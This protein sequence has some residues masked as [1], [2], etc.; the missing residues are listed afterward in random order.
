MT[1]VIERVRAAEQALGPGPAHFGLMH[2]DLHHHNL[3][4]ARGA[5]KARHR[6]GDRL[7]RLWLRPAALRP[8]GAAGGAAG[9]ARRYPALRAALLAGYRRV[10]PLPPAHEAYLDTFIALRRVQDALWVLASR[11]HPAI[12]LDWAAQAR[13]MMA[14]L[15]GFLARGAASPRA[16]DPSITTRV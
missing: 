1:A 3:L 11:R 8:R 15:A 10:R 16:A 9:P 5:V 14:P 13:R 7:R 12:G 2:A 4:F 6:E